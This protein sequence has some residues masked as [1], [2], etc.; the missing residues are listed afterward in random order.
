M[1]SSSVLLRRSARMV[2]CSAKNTMMRQSGCAV[3][4]ASQ[5]SANIRCFSSAVAKLQEGIQ[6]ELQFEKENYQKPEV[7]DKISKEWKLTDEPGDVNMKIEKDLGS[8]KKCVIE[9]QLVSPFDPEMDAEASAD[10]EKPPESPPDETDFTISISS[11]EGAK[12]MQYF[13]STQ[14]GEG[15]RFVIGSL[16]NWTSLKE[17]DS[18]SAYNGP[19]FEDLEPSLQESMDEYLGEIG[20]TNEVYDFI[21]SSAVDKELREYMRWLENLKDFMKA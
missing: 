6:S 19:D 14:Q 16:K 2:G 8:G 11:D 9:W 12:G 21:D 4:N 10:G 3:T 17:R 15:H 1:R 20:V 7:F 13:C 5:H 18:M